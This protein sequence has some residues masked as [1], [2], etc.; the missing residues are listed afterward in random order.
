MLNIKLK[1][2]HYNP[3]WISFNQVM[4]NDKEKPTVLVVADELFMMADDLLK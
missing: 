3:K 1:S 2:K 4:I